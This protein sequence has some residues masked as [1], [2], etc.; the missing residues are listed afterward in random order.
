[1][2]LFLL[3]FA[4]RN[5]SEDWLITWL[6]LLIPDYVGYSELKRGLIGLIDWFSSLLTMLA[7]RYWSEG[8]LIT[9]FILFIPDCVGYQELNRGGH[10]MRKRRFIFYSCLPL[11]PLPA[12]SIN[13]LLLS[14]L[15]FSIQIKIMWSNNLIGYWEWVHSG[16][17][18]V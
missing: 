16:Y 1:M 10:A 15:G 14:V 2:S 9:W 8:W 3:M 17:T 18:L 4:I 5:W 7:I 6:I 11:F 13:L 12:V